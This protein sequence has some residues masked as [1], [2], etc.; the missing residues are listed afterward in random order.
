MSNKTIP[1]LQKP[2]LR[3]LEDRAPTLSGSSH[4]RYAILTDPERTRVFLAVLIAEGGGNFN[5]EAV[6]VNDIAQTLEALPAG[7]PFGSK[8]IQR[9]YAGRSSNNAG[10]ACAVLVH[11]G[12]LAPADGIK[13]KLVR[14]GD[15]PAWQA[16]MLALEGE[17]ILFPPAAA[18]APAAVL[19]VAPSVPTADKPA[20]KKSGKHALPAAV[21][22]AVA[23]GEHMGEVEHHAEHP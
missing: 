6:A 13:H 17:E 22:A 19:A 3:V 20:K 18:Q 14:V 23:V 12:L 7:E 15:W 11:A 4:L 21:K 8:A 9:C 10:Y 16:A 2:F 1:V 5:K